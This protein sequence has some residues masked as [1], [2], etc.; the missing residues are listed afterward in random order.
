MFK[1]IS[2]TNWKMWLVYWNDPPH[3][4]DSYIGVATIIR[5]TTMSVVTFNTLWS[6]STFEDTYYMIWAI[7]HL[8]RGF[9]MMVYVKLSKNGA[10][11]ADDGHYKGVAFIKSNLVLAFNTL[12]SSNLQYWCQTCYHHLHNALALGLHKFWEWCSQGQ[13]SLG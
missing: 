12:L 2:D 13:R 5:V 6:S 8:I 4:R 1:Y 7:L 11:K 9:H 10:G 3:R